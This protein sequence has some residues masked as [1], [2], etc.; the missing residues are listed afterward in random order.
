MVVSFTVISYIGVTIRVP[1][2][3]R[4]ADLRPF[5]KIV[6][7]NRDKVFNLGRDRKTTFRLQKPIVLLTLLIK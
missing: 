4:R 7:F 2:N 3:K 6:S 5:V 1:V